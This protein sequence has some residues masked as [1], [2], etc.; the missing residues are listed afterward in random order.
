[1]D[2]YYAFSDA[3]ESIGRATFVRFDTIQRQEID[4]LLRAGK[5]SKVAHDIRP[6]LFELTIE[7]GGSESFDGLD[8]RRI[9]PD[10][11]YRLSVGNEG[12]AATAYNGPDQSDGK[13]IRIK[14]VAFLDG[15]GKLVRSLTTLVSLDDEPDASEDDI[16]RM[17][18]LP[19]IERTFV[20]V[21]NVGQGSCSAVCMALALPLIYY[22][23]GG[24]VTRNA[25][26]YPKD[27][28]FCFSENPPVVLSHWDLDHWV[29]GLK[30]PNALDLKWLVPRQRMGATHLKFAN[31]LQSRNNLLIWPANLT[32]VSF[33]YGRIWK[34]PKHRNRN[35]SGLVLVAQVNDGSDSA[36][37]LCPG[38]S[39]YGQVP[40]GAGSS[41]HGLIA[42]HHGGNYPGDYPPPPAGS[43][44]IVYSFGVCN[45]YNHP[46]SAAVKRHQ[47]SGW[48]HRRDTPTGHAALPPIQPVSPLAAC[49]GG[50]LALDVP[51][52]ADR[53]NP[54]CHA[55]TVS[56]VCLGNGRGYIFRC[57]KCGGVELWHIVKNKI[58]KSHVTDCPNATGS[59]ICEECGR[60]RGMLVHFAY[61]GGT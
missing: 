46:R 50:P 44:H 13:P 1:M 58:T 29:S 37:V 57:R 32:D 7:R 61:S 30:H 9:E 28:R 36:N 16:K 10:R 45:S 25:K 2:H 8:G 18:D 31:K 11:W 19:R 15:R 34:L 51:L 60:G 24:G 17:L 41:F 20:G 54:V 22:D 5:F 4:L 21:Y 23:F 56:A 40:T 48:K 52:L 33:S 43:G 6:Q 47:S 14:D 3:V 26:T 27:L 35:Y 38:D 49:H 39:P 59:I 53:T 42:T 55:C 12:Q